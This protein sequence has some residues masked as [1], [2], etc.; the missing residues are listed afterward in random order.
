MPEVKPGFLLSVGELG[1]LEEP[2]I[3]ERLHGTGCLR[4]AKVQLHFGE[5]DSGDCAQEENQLQG[6]VYWTR[7]HLL[8]ES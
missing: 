3:R 6:N 5:G 1:F 2:Q 8:N 4:Q 7:V